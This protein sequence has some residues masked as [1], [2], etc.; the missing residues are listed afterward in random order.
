M[1]FLVPVWAAQGVT[2]E[3]GGRTAPS[4]GALYPLGVYVVVGNVE[5]LDAGL[6]SYEPEKHRLAR[7]EE[8][9][10][11]VELAE[12]A[13]DQEWV[14]E[15]A[16]DIVI[17]AVYGR[18]TQKYGEKGVRYARMETGHAAQNVC[19]Q[20]TALDLGLV[21]VGAFYDSRVSRMLQLPGNEGPLYITP[22][23]WV[24]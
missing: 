10:L 22:V 16:I 21:T 3:W 18:T 4:A 1:N 11:R 9:E 15:G 13:L 24:R 2:A 5:G 20:A 17:S 6:Y 7:L 14:K 8:R 19:L 12:A 23:G